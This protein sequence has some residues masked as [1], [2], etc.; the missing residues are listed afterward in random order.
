MIVAHPDDET[1][2]AGGMIL[3]HPL[4]KWHIVTLCRAG[5]PDRAPRFSRA[6]REF[7][8]TGNMADL[9]DGPGQIP[10]DEDEVR[11]TIRELLPSRHFDLI[12]SHNPAGEYTRHRRHEEVARAVISLWHAGQLS[13]AELWT[14]AY[15]DG[16]RRYLPKPMEAASI[17]H[18]LPEDIWRAKYRIITETY[19]FPP[20]GFE[21][22]TTPHAEAFWQ[23][24]S[25]R[26]AQAWLE[27]GGV[28]S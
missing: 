3:S 2:W 6:L 28:L 26:D 11:R 16:G 14:F 24:T 7:G 22:Q 27:R 21:A 20:D 15:E 25:P 17:Y 8:A 23:F 13:A 12:L 18:V 19:G 1:L 9:D 10:L 4:W 5:D